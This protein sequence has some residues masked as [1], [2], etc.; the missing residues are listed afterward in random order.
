MQN[1]HFKICSSSTLY[2]KKSTHRINR[3]HFS[4]LKWFGLSC[5]YLTQ[6]E[7][8]FCENFRAL[9]LLPSS[10]SSSHPFLHT[11][12]YSAS[13]SLTIEKRYAG[14]TVLFYSLSSVIFY[15]ILTWYKHC[16]LESDLFQFA[17]ILNCQWRETWRLVVAGPFGFVLFIVECP[18]CYHVGHLWGCSC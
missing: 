17:S 3:T 12:T 13:Y 16:F 18:H 14:G 5:S 11:I 4:L 15:V 7:L 1:Q 8:F 9:F 6:I 2:K 10:F